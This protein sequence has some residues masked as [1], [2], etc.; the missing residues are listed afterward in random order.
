MSFSLSEEDWKTVANELKGIG[1]PPT[2]SERKNIETMCELFVLE[3]LQV[4]KV[5]PNPAIQSKRWKAAHKAAT[6][7][8]ENLRVIADDPRAA[9]V[10][11]WIGAD[12]MQML[13]GVIHQTAY[14]AE[15]EKLGPS[16]PNRADPHHDEFFSALLNFWTARGGGT[17]ISPNTS[18]GGPL[19]RF[20]MA[21]YG[22]ALERV[23]MGLPKP[24]NIKDEVSKHKE[25][26]AGRG[27]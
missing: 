13:H 27:K 1:W 20:M 17:G 8:Y 2:D 18:T 4:G 23:G 6:K 22:R 9:D 7:L 12:F 24:Q 21:T 19:V 11:L 5:Q 15:I 16:V 3:R 25:R 10:D 26:L 14:L